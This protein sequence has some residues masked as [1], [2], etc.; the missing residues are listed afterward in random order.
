MTKEESMSQN[1]PIC[2]HALISG[3]VQGVGFRNFVLVTAQDMQLSGW[4]RNRWDGTVE[5]SAEGLQNDLEIFLSRLKRGPSSAR[6]TQVKVNWQPAS[7][8]Y[9][10]FHVRSTV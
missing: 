2:L 9:H 3:R 10:G 8:T 4:V 6:V 7:Q 1:S 5:V